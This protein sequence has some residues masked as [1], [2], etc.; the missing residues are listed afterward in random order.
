MTTKEYIDRLEYLK[1]RLAY[2]MSGMA[3]NSG[4]KQGLKRIEL[5][6]QEIKKLK[7]DS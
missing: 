4:F 3:T 6:N 5:W 2:R 1:T 7:K